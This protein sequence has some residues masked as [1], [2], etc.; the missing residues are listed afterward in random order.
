MGQWG[1]LL[2]IVSCFVLV[3]F[4]LEARLSLAGCLTIAFLHILDNCRYFVRNDYIVGSLNRSIN[5]MY[6]RKL[7]IIHNCMN[8]TLSHL[9]MFNIVN[10]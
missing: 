2:L 9:N 6:L 4:F 10:V 3:L 7:K 8:K 1:F 5:V